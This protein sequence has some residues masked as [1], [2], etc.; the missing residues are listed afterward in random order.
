[1]NTY[2]DL[3]HGSAYIWWPLDLH[4]WWLLMRVLPRGFETGISKFFPKKFYNIFLGCSRAFGSLEPALC[5]EARKKPCQSSPRIRDRALGLEGSP[6]DAVWILCGSGSCSSPYGN[7]YVC[8]L[9][10]RVCNC[11]LSYQFSPSL[12][13]LLSSCKP[14]LLLQ[15][16][17]PTPAEILQSLLFSRKAF[18]NHS[19][20]FHTWNGPFSHLPLYIDLMLYF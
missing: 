1:M 8:L 18:L 7:E 3:S 11:L 20:V 19:P 9:G 16:R 4:Q 10:W 5:L 6:W 15:S 17:Q 14:C 13:L 12:S 2:S